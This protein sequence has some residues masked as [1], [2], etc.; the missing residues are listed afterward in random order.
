M[1]QLEF[2]HKAHEW[3]LFINLSKV[4]LEVFLLHNRNKKPSVPVAHA[5]ELKE[6]PEMCHI[7]IVIRYKEH[8]W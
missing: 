7:L 3:Q 8:H 4:S 6:T 2:E 1:E 5:V